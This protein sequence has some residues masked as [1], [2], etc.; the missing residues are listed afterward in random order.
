MVGYEEW[1]IDDDGLITASSGHY[2]ADEYA[3]Q[4]AHGV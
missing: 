3:R 1:T 4:L 2:D